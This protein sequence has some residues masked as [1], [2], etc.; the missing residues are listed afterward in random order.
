MS[1][2]EGF[3]QL[4]AHARLC[5]WLSRHR[6]TGVPI[7]MCVRLLG[8]FGEPVALEAGH[9]CW[10]ISKGSSRAN[11]TRL[12]VTNIRCCLCKV[13]QNSTFQPVYATSGLSLSY[14]PAPMALAFSSSSNMA[15]GKSCVPG[16]VS[17]CY[18]WVA[19]T[20][21]ECLHSFCLQFH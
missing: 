1:Q 14:V 13:P 7:Q 18:H 5:N 17:H 4:S 10:G 12:V 15:V 21:E 2:V 20:T 6:G 9:V 16:K 19:C 11:V 8:H 3:Q